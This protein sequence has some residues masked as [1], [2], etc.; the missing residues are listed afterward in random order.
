M[1]VRTSDWQS[2]GAGQ[3]EDLS[4]ILTFG[5]GA[6]ISRDFLL[7]TASPSAAQARFGGLNQI[8][9]GPVMGPIKSNG[10]AITVTGTGVISG[11][12]DGVDAFAHS[13]TK[14]TNSGAINGAAGTAS[15]AGGLG[16]SNRETIAA[17]INKGSIG[18]GAG[19]AGSIKGGAGGAGVLNAGAIPTLTNSGAIIGGAGGGG[20]KTG[21]AGGAGVSN[22]QGA[23]ITTLTNSGTISGGNGGLDAIGA[24]G[25]GGAGVSNAGTVKTL[26]NSGTIK[27]GNGGDSPPLVKDFA[28]L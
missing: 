18:G 19:G 10:G 26:S 20:K 2:A 1:G 25:A 27:G 12:P 16:V 24:G 5:G 17:L 11:G 6:P 9:S 13:I 4:D 22:A 14:L 28:G 7:A 8:I 15:A 21:G 3:V 23:T